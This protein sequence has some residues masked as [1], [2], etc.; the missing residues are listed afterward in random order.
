MKLYHDQHSHESLNKIGSHT[1]NKL[2]L[3]LLRGKRLANQV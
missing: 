1:D 3:T 2:I